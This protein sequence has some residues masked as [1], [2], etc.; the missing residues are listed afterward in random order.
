MSK[1]HHANVLC[2]PVHSVGKS[3]TKYKCLCVC[4]EELEIMLLILSTHKD[5]VGTGWPSVTSTKWFPG[6]LK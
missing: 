6:A 2:L 3:I 5:H 1:Y 4:I